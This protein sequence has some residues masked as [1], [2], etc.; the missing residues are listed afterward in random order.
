[1][2]LSVKSYDVSFHPK[3]RREESIFEGGEGKEREREDKKRGK[4]VGG[5]IQA[6]FPSYCSHTHQ[7]Q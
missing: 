5:S 3:G 2:E 7:L 1:L 4:E 6:R